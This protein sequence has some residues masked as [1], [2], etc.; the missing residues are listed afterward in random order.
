MS[1]LQLVANLAYHLRYAAV[2]S[3]NATL[4]YK[5]VETWSSLLCLQY[6]NFCIMQS[7]SQ[8]EGSWNHHP[9]ITVLKKNILIVKQF[10][11]GVRTKAGN[12]W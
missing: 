8:A 11:V 9:Q 6:Y 5:T 1:K 12:T 4:H 2:H 3:F 7:Y 10:W